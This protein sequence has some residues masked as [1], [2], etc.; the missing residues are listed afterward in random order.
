MSFSNF[1]LNIVTFWNPFLL[2]LQHMESEVAQFSLNY[3][4]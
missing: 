3:D 1:H 2:L 4:S